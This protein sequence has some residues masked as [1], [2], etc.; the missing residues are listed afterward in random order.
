MQHVLIA[1]DHEV[2]RR[3]VRDILADAYAHIDIV[4]AVDGASVQRQ[5][6]SQPWDLLL[7]DI[8]MPDTNILTLLSII[9]TTLP[10]VPILLLTASNEMSYV[11]Q[12]MKAGA[13]GLIHKHRAADE[14][15]RAIAQVTQGGTYLHPET[16]ARIAQ[17]LGNDDTNLPHQ[18]LSQRELEIFRM[19]AMGNTTKEIAHTLH[20]S[21]KTVAT[22]LGRIREKTGLSSLVEI[23]RYALQKGLVE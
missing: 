19:I 5:L 8:C 22:Y 2:T 17:T 1:D 16:A 9:R 3:G 4:D 14:L 6:T 12:T 20:I 23:A 7:L 13:N 21:A 11:I 10:S 18:V 15:L